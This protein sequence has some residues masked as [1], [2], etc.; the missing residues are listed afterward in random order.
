MRDDD[1]FDGFPRHYAGEMPIP[2]FMRGCDTKTGIDD[3]PAFAIFIAVLQQPQID[4]VEREWQGH[5][6]PMD[7]R[8]DKDGF[9]RGRRNF[10][11]IGN[12]L[13]FD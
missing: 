9:S 10:V 12:H 2:K 6:N 5:S 3:G 13:L 1:T 7:T 4:M 11:R 8:C